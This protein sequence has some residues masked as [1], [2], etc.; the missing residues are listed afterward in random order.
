MIPRE[1]LWVI[2]FH[3]RSRFL[4]TVPRRINF[5]IWINCQLSRLLDVTLRLSP[6][7]RCCC[8]YRY[9]STGGWAELERAGKKIVAEYEMTM[10]AMTRATPSLSIRSS[11]IDDDQAGQSPQFRLFSLRWGAHGGTRDCPSPIESE[12]NEELSHARNSFRLSPIAL[13]SV[14]FFFVFFLSFSWTILV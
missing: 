13:L 4:E 11:A 5:A 2:S 14:F 9:R 6:C 8:H 10:N 12:R 3:A 7:C 1:D